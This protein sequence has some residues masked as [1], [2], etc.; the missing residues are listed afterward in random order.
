MCMPMY[1][2]II[3]FLCVIY[4]KPHVLYVEYQYRK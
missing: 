1:A 4:N 3:R 2:I